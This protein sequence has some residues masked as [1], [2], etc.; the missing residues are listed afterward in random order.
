MQWSIAGV[1]LDEQKV[2]HKLE[3][4]KKAGPTGILLLGAD[5]AVKSHIVSKLWNNLSGVTN[6]HPDG[7]AGPDLAKGKFVVYNPFG[8]LAIE[9]EYRQKYIQEFYD[10]GAKHVVMVWVKYPNQ[11]GWTTGLG[12]AQDQV[13]RDNP[14]EEP[15]DLLIEVEELG[16]S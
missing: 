7:G 16:R 10:D 2:Y 11:L 12:Q 6:L 15:V 9:P 1:A 14:P 4:L 3:E 8:N 5:G 13:L